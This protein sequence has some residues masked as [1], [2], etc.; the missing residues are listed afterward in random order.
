MRGR[1]MGI[2]T[3]LKSGKLKEH[4]TIGEKKE[5]YKK[6]SENKKLSESQ[7]KY[8]L[9]RLAELDALTEKKTALSKNFVGRDGDLTGNKINPNKARYGVC[10]KI[11]KDGTLNINPFMP[12]KER[13]IEKEKQVEISAQKALGSREHA[14]RVKATTKVMIDNICEDKGFPESKTR[15]LT[16]EEYHKLKKLSQ[17]NKKKRKQ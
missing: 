12:R 14:A 13:E 10:T 16:S 11:R 7:R 15:K 1:N 6:R 5:Y 8:A 2:F 3:K 9:K 4:F 17:G